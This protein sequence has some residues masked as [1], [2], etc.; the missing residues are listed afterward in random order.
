M[1][2]ANYDKMSLLIEHNIDDIF[3]VVNTE[4]IWLLSIKVV[5]AGLDCNF[6]YNH[7]QIKWIM[8]IIGGG[9]IL[10]LLSNINWDNKT[11]LHYSVELV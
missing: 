4:L 8:T 3:H 11:M 1:F 5:Y 9:Y 6:T 7:V 10:V 2:A